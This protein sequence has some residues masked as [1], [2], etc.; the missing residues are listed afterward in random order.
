MWVQ[1]ACIILVG[2][3]SLSRPF[4]YLGLP[5][6]KIFVG[7]VLLVCFLLCGPR[8]GNQSW[9]RFTMRLQSLRKFWVSYSLFFIYGICEVLYGI[10]QGRPVLMCIR[11]L[12]FQYYPL[13]FLLGLWVGV[14][15]PDLL[16]KVIRSF[17]WFNGIYGVLYI[18]FFSRV[19]WFMP[20][21]SDEVSPVAVFAEPLYSFVALLGLMV[22][23]KQP[24]RSWYLLLLNGFVLLG[25]QFRTEWL[26]L[27]VGAI[28]W[29]FVTHR[30]RQ[31]LQTGGVLLLLFGVLYVTNLSIP[32]PEGRAE[33]DFSARQTVDRAVAPF[34]ADLT[35]TSAAAGIT[36]VDSQ[37]ATFLFR[38]VWW[39]AI[40]E[41]SHENVRSALL[42]QG[43]GYELGDLVP[44]LKD[45][46]IRTPHNAL[47]YAL[48]YTGW[49]GVFLFV[50]FQAEVVRLLWRARNNAAEP[51]G[52]ALWAAMMTLAM[53]FP[54][55]ET[56]YGAIPF[57]LLIGMAAGKGVHAE[58]SL[59]EV[60]RSAGSGELILRPG[61]A[62]T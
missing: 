20:G 41:A 28:T 48:G 55:G 47:F 23:D 54:L 6:W 29:C 10:V 25:M 51:F 58:L 40:W 50:F 39:L 45:H 1:I 2:Y 12:A 52:I 11:D 53:F 8:V 43:Y 34:R 27:L 9:I 16:P 22:F 31:V 24:L 26:A 62:T 18:L 46:F 17:A 61:H 35:D 57:F 15:R 21:V 4:A 44:Y 3:L 56:P 49:I 30:A 19:Q 42:G 38:T 13:Y 5:A 33:S 7:E 60:S 14:K 37:E 36:T 32:S 59:Q